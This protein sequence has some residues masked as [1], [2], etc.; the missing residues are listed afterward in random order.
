MTLHSQKIFSV[1]NEDKGRGDTAFGTEASH[2]TAE[3]ARALEDWIISGDVS[4][5][6]KVGRPSKFDVYR[7]IF[8]QHIE[9]TASD[10]FVKLQQMGRG[11]TQH[12]VRSSLT[13]YWKKGL[14]ERKRVQNIF[15][16]WLA[17]EGGTK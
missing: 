9:L 7:A 1:R 3:Q 5:P 13:E 17:D 8:Q 11:V 10:V 15:I 2:Y 16:Y 4:Q 6:P 12:S 14:L